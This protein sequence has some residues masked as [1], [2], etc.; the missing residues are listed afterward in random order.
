MNIHVLQNVG[1]D[2]TVYADL[3][4][5]G[6]GQGSQA[7]SHIHGQ[8]ERVQYADIDYN[9]K[10]PPLT[11]EELIAL[12]VEATESYKRP[13]PPLPPHEPEGATLAAGLE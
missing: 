8:E 6:F 9:K 11:D 12:E 5:T 7:A 3:D 2:G 13:Q 10:V 1:P 4:I